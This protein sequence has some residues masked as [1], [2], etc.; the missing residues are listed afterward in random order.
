MFD[1][2]GKIIGNILEINYN[3][4]SYDF[5]IIG[6]KL[7]INYDYN[8]MI[9]QIYKAIDNNA[10]FYNRCFYIYIADYDQPRYSCLDMHESLFRI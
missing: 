2:E 9:N 6:N 8:I 4:S 1:E 5:I 7:V 3:H 10:G